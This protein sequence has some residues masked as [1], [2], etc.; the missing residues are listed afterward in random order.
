[1][2][3]PPSKPCHICH[4]RSFRKNTTVQTSAAYSCLYNTHDNYSK[5]MNDKGKRYIYIYTPI[6]LSATFLSLGGAA[7]NF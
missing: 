2:E 5:I 7:A 3:K 1:M 6:L 4:I